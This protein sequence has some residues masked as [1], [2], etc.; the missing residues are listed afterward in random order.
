MGLADRTR[1]RMPNGVV[2]GRTEDEINIEKLTRKDIPLKIVLAVPS[3]KISLMNNDSMSQHELALRRKYNDQDV[4]IVSHQLEHMELIDQ[5]QLAMDTTI[6][7]S[8]CGGSAVTAMF[9]PKGASLV[10]FYSE[11]GGRNHVNPLAR[12][13]WDILNNL[14]YLRVHWLPIATMDTEQDVDAFLDL[15]DHEINLHRKYFK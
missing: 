6:F 12:R 7:V 1:P 14:S 15:V 4:E 3:S 10:V 13:S 9:M 8:F 11:I 2:D 5:I